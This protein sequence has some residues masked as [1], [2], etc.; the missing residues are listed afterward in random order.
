MTESSSNATIQALVTDNDD[1]ASSTG[2]SSVLYTTAVPGSTVFQNT[3]TSFVGPASDSGPRS[4]FSTTSANPDIV[5]NPAYQTSTNLT[6]TTSYTPITSDVYRQ[7]ASD[8]SAHPVYDPTGMGSVVTNGTALPPLPSRTTSN[9]KNVPTISDTAYSSSENPFNASGRYTVHGSNAVPGSTSNHQ[10]NTTALASSLYTPGSSGLPVRYPTNAT[11][12]AAWYHTAASSGSLI[13]YPS[14][15][16]TARPSSRHS[17]NSSVL[18]DHTTTITSG[19]TG[20]SAQESGSSGFTGASQSPGPYQ[21]VSSSED[22]DAIVSRRRKTESQCRRE[23][24]EWETEFN[25]ITTSG[26][27]TALWQDLEYFPSFFPWPST[28]IFKTITNNQGLKNPRECCGPCKISWLDV[29]VKYWPQDGS[30]T[31]C[32]SSTGSQAGY[33]A[34]AVA[35]VMNHVDRIHL[36]YY[37][38]HPEA[39]P[40]EFRKPQGQITATPPYYDEVNRP[41]VPPSQSKVRRRAVTEISLSLPSIDNLVIDYPDIFAGTDGSITLNGTVIGATMPA[42]SEKG[43]A[44]T[45]NMPKDSSSGP[46]PEGLVSVSL[47]TIPN[48]NH[49]Q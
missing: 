14:N 21:N 3:S 38:K 8:P 34:E 44:A 16:A 15:M 28:E 33:L 40:G 27:Y 48:D 46:E 1:A 45:I 30:N 5:G 42:S 23:S 4:S 29:T 9:V 18:A 20:R 31:E 7:E 12:S 17:V 47:A 6:A 35:S 37:Q 24:L 11:A 22:P 2:Y 49:G 43:N 13:K 19:P 36:D 32:L 39:D 25:T 41:I 10:T 26:V